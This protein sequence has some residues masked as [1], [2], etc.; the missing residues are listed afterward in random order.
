MLIIT[1][2]HVWQDNEDDH[3]FLLKIWVQSYSVLDVLDFGASLHLHPYYKQWW[4][5]EQKDKNTEVAPH[6]FKEMLH[7]KSTIA[8]TESESSE[9]LDK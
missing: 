8:R 9:E 4:N 6:W 1:K 5:S 3:I 2:C 7:V